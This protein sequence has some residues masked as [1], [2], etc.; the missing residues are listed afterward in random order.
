[1]TDEG[2][3]VA[4]VRSLRKRRQ[5]ARRSRRAIPCVST[6]YISSA[7]PGSPCKIERSST[8]SPPAR[9]SRISDMSTCASLQPWPP[10]RTPICRSM[11]ACSPQTEGQV[12][13][14]REPGKGSHPAP[15]FLRLIL[16]WEHALCH[17]LVHL[18]GAGF[19]CSDSTKIPYQRGFSAFAKILMVDHGPPIIDEPETATAAGRASSGGAIEAATPLIR[20]RRGRSP[21]QRA[22]PRRSALLAGERP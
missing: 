14:G 5:S 19:R 22:R 4:D 20:D 11:D 8:Q 9:L 3:G 6:R 2:E 16:E 7:K 1:M 13:V 10:R 17:T 18:V 12:Q 15:V 21:G